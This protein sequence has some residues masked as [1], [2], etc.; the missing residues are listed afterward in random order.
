MYTRTGVGLVLRGLGT[1]RCPQASLRHVRARGRAG[2]LLRDRNRPGADAKPF[3][4]TPSR[5]SIRWVDAEVDL[6]EW[7]GKRIGLRLRCES[8]RGNVAFWSS[9][10]IAG[11]RSAP[12]NVLLVLEDAERA[13]HLSLYGYERPTTPVKDRFAAGGVVFERAFS[14]APKTRPSCPSL[15]TSTLPEC[16][17]RGARGDAGAAVT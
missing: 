10:I 7:A 12:F 8:G 4:R 3:I 15:M 1:P 13:N 11:R 5:S 6:S 9:P 2:A 17:R 14:Q 16:D